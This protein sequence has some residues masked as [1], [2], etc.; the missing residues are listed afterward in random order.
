MDLIKRIRPIVVGKLGFHN[1][2]PWD[3]ESHDGVGWCHYVQ[4]D[5][6]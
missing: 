4:G 1:N 3:I 6:Y 2:K 5:N